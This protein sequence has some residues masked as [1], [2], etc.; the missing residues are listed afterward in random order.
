[1]RGADVR[2]NKDFKVAN[3]NIFKELKEIVLKEVKE[4]VMTMSYYVENTN[5]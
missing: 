1:M 5:R 4:D 2:L 3:I